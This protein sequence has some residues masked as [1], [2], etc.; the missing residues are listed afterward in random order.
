MLKIVL[1]DKEYDSNV[2]KYTKRD[3]IFAFILFGIIMVHYSV[4]ALLQ[5]NWEFIKENIMVVGCLFNL[6]LILIT[7][8]FVK[9]NKQSL[10]T[11]GIFKGKWQKS[12]NIGVFLALFVFYNNCVS[13]LFN[14]SQLIK[15]SEIF[16]LLIYYLFVAVCEELVFRGYI[17]T[18]IYGLI[19]R[20]G[21][22]IFVVGILF[23]I[24]HFPYRM[25]AYGVTLSDLTIKNFNWILDL[26]IT[27]LILNFIYLKTNSL[28]GAILPH[29]MSN[30]AYHIILK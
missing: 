1:V 7:L 5:I 10:D 27:H 9:I 22:A 14:G 26:F 4:L 17:G 23:I 18:R 25:I 21:V 28:Y 30:F 20:R 2:K 24:M 11:I 13:Y 19:K 12:I 6:F 8:L 29:W 3:G 15:W 16:L